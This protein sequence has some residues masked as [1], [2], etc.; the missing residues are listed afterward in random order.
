ME[1]RKMV[2][3][4]WKIRKIVISKRLAYLIFC[5]KY[6][7]FT[8]LLEV[9]PCVQLYKRGNLVLN[10]YVW[11]KDMLLAQSMACLDCL[12]YFPSPSYPTNARVIYGRSW[13]QIPD[14]PG[15]AQM[16]TSCQ[17]TVIQMKIIKNNYFF[18]IKIIQP[19]LIYLNTLNQQFL[20]NQLKCQ[21]NKIYHFR[22]L[23]GGT[24][25]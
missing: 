15:S 4:R 19:D 12:Y 5:Q 16:L 10:V 25:T 7:L 11:F 9:P 13:V 21:R 6:S 14:P 8:I 3:T 22:H 2:I 24:G 1:I 18:L 23:F 17:K 20:Q